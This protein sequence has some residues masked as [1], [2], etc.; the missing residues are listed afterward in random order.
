MKKSKGLSNHK[1]SEEGSCIGKDK[2]TRIEAERR[3]KILKAKTNGKPFDAYKCQ[4][5]CKLLDGGIAWHVGHALKPR[6]HKRPAK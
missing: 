1:Q 6:K 2:L 5:E 4:Y 3:A